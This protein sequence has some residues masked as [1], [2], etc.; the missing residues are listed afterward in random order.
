MDVRQTGRI[1]KYIAEHFIS[2][3]VDNTLV[4]EESLVLP[5]WLSQ[6]MLID[7]INLLN[8]REGVHVLNDLCTQLCNRDGKV[9]Q[10]FG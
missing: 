10:S 5:R 1:K 2:V 8:R 9:E 6:E 3:T 4:P 7:N